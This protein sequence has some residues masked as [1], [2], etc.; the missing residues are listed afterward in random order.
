MGESG[1]NVMEEVRV[2]FKGRRSNPLGFKLRELTDNFSITLFELITLLLFLDE[3]L[4]CNKGHHRP[5][6]TDVSNNL[7]ISKL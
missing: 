5:L 1:W 6:L 7:N 4:G 3:G 2:I